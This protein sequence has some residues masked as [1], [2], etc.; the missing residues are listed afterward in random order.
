[1]AVLVAAVWFLYWR[2]DDGSG[3]DGVLCGGLGALNSRLVVSGHK[4]SSPAAGIEALPAA[5][6]LPTVAIASIRSAQQHAQQRDGTCL[7]VNWKWRNLSPMRLQLRC[8]ALRCNCIALYCAATGS[9][10][11][12]PIVVL[13]QHRRGL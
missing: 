7:P 13:S 5:R 8:I 1:M 4:A 11:H 2:G 10:T 3:S 6:V 9:S 12:A